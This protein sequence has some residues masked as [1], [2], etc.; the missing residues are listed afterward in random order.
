MEPPAWSCAARFAS[1]FVSSYSGNG[2]R[3]LSPIWEWREPS[4]QELNHNGEVTMAHM[5][6]HNIG[7]AAGV[8]R[9]YAHVDHFTRADDPLGVARG[10]IFGIVISVLG[11]WLPLAIALIR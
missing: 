5:L 8:S 9:R 10:V 11:F 6:R 7:P 2:V 3:P 4:N 1:A